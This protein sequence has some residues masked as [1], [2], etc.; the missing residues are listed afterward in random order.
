VD[1]IERGLPDG[2]R[3]ADLRGWFVS[4][5]RVPAEQERHPQCEGRVPG[6]TGRNVRYSWRR[7]RRR[8]GCCPTPQA[9]D[10]GRPDQRPP[11]KVRKQRRGVDHGRGAVRRAEDRDGHAEGR[12]RAYA[13]GQAGHPEC[14]C[15]RD[16]PRCHRAV[17]GWIDDPYWSARSRPLARSSHPPGWR[18]RRSG[19]G[20]GVPPLWLGGDGDRERPTARRA[21]GPGCGGGAL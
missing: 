15:S 2:T 18:L 12:R 13:R 9:S 14:R 3:R 8:Y 10:S 4:E 1:P 17:G 20:A 21:R 5:H 11:R 7:D 6:G 16:D 19:A